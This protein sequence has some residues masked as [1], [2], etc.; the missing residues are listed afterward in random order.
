[1]QMITIKIGEVESELF[2]MSE[3][4][5]AEHVNRR[6][7]DVGSVCIQIKVEHPSA[8]LT[9]STQ[10]CPRSGGGGRQANQLECRIFDLWNEKRLA[11]GDIN[12]GQLKQF[13]KELQR[14]L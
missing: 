10:D 2:G 7:K 8:N 4:W 13:L 11:N 9:L 12:L 1:M 14:M 3:S 5:L 6:K